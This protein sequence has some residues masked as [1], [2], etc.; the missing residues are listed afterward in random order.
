MPY[1]KRN[2]ALDITQ[3]PP[4]AANQQDLEA[5]RPLADYR[6]HYVNFRYPMLSML[7][8]VFAGGENT[9]YCD[10]TPDFVESYFVDP[11]APQD[12]QD[13]Q[14]AKAQRLGLAVGPTVTPPGLEA[15]RQNQ[16]ERTADSQDVI[17]ASSAQ[18]DAILA[19][20]KEELQ[21]ADETTPATPMW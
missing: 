3:V 9:L 21:Q 14:R 5:I 17:V 16:R 2:K 19:I 8:A 6:L 10:H 18:W 4:N 1:F 11:N 15:E 20:L 7:Y 13:A 12:V